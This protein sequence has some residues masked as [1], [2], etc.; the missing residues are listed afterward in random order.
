MGGEEGWSAKDA[1]AVVTEE[2]EVQQEAIERYK[3]GDNKTLKSAVKDIKEQAVRETALE[4]AE[5]YKPD[6]RTELHVTAV[7]DLKNL[8]KPETV[9]LIA[10]DPPYEQAALPAIKHLTEFA[11][12]ALKPGGTLLVMTG[13]E[14]LPQIIKT[15]TENKLT[16]RWQIAY[17]M[18]GPTSRVRHRSIFQTWKP[19]IWV[20][21]GNYN[22]PMI[23]DIVEPA[24][25]TEDNM[26]IK[27]HKWG[28]TVTGCTAILD[29][30]INPNPQ[31]RTRSG[32]Y[33]AG[34]IC[35]PMVGGGGFALAAL[36]LQCSRFIGADIDPQAIQTTKGR[37]T[38]A[39][40]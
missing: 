3:A 40:L 22:G 5:Q 29:P 17:L 28:Q 35:D 32:T 19:I 33:A 11:E 9:D 1:A 37:I 12:H 18:R 8:V 4:K 25:Q 15:L 21:K 6:G 34:T 36:T 39:Q 7:A 23:R 27:H 24:L 16:Y 2:P 10:T 26:T 31:N 13:N 20:T 38:D 14:H 30:F